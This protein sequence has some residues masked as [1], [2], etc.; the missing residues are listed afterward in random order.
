MTELKN[1]VEPEIT[2]KTEDNK[3]KPSIVN[4]KGTQLPQ[5]GKPD[6][7]PTQSNFQNDHTASAAHLQQQPDENPSD[8]PKWKRKTLDATLV[9]VAIVGYILAT[10][11][12]PN[13]TASFALMGAVFATMSAV[14]DFADYPSGTEKN[15]V[16]GILKIMPVILIIYKVFSDS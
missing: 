15:M 14:I 2:I 13:E 10:A 6:Q 5:T 1:D 8:Y 3:N 11:F 16:S 12:A 4:N 9:V 7:N